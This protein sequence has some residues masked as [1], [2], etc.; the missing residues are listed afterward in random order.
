MV[1]I[2]CSPASLTEMF[3]NLNEFAKHIHTCS[4]CNPMQT[5]ALPPHSRAK[6]TLLVLES[7]S[8][9]SSYCLGWRD[10]F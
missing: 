8:S 9:H 2:T 5:A 1:N 3:K 4:Q 6:L 7:H 10:E